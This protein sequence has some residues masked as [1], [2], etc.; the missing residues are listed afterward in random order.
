M[1]DNDSFSEVTTESWFDR[2]RESIKGVATGL[3]LAVVA[4]P[5]LFW[6]EGRAVKTARGREE[7]AGAVVSVKPDAVDPKNDRKLI[8]TT[9]LATT[10]ETLRDDPF[11]VSAPGIKLIREVEMYQWREKKQTRRKKEGG[12][13]VKVTT[14]DYEKVWSAAPI[15]SGEFKRPLGH[16]NPKRLP[17]E[18]RT[19]RA[20]SVTL[21]AIALPPALVDKIGGAEALPVTERM[22]LQMK[23]HLA[24]HARLVAG[25]YYFGRRPSE[26][27]IG[28]TRVRFKVVPPATVSVVAQQVGGT[29]APYATQTGSTIQLLQMGTLDAKAMFTSA[30]ASNATLTWILRGVGLVLLFLGLLL[31]FNPLAVLADVIP[32]VGDLL[33][34]GIAAFAGVATVVLGGLTIAIAW[35]GHRPLVGIPLLVGSL[36]LLVG[37]KLLGHG[38]KGQGRR[39]ALSNT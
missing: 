24:E 16:E 8:H 2:I 10:D 4:F 22:A 13:Q 11:G 21:G 14:Y 26:P 37:L 36:A 33:R 32:F 18:S 34:F 19:F 9:G 30:L 3:L 39:A 6:N 38:R 29:L 28:D 23:P 31:I 27:A 25:G 20:K 12:K 15:D 1:S 35:V 17:Y 7:G 5:L